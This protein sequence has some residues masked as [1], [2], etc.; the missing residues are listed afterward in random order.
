M[1]EHLVAPLPP[2]ALE[3][4][5]QWLF[6]GTLASFADWQQAGPGNFDFDAAEQVLVARPGAEIGLLFYAAAA[7]S[8]FTLRLQFRLDSR[9]DNSGIFVRFPRPAAACLRSGSMILASLPTLLGSPST[10]DS[11]YR[12]MRPL[13]P[14][15][16]TSTGQGAIYDIDIGPG[17][18]SRRYARGSSLQPGEWNDCEIRVL[19]NS[20]EALLNG[21]TTAALSTTQ[22]RR[23]D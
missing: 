3:A 2:P 4:G 16:R 11:K 10:Q 19:G 5:Y 22:T 18:A 13:S 23:G 17:P 12:S 15:K 21:F 1:A 7:F 8:D 6:D 20:Y 9:N 14:T